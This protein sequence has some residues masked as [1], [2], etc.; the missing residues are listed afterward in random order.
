MAVVLNVLTF[1]FLND[2]PC[3]FILYYTLRAIGGTR[4]HVAPRDTRGYTREILTEPVS[5]PLARARVGGCERQFISL[6]AILCERRASLHV[7]KE[8]E[9]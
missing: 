6:N 5:F 7:V 3:D 2:P 9:S 4:L 1:T 8:R